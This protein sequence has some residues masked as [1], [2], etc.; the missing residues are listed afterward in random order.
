MEHC[1]DT[2]ATMEDVHG[3]LGA[4]GS[5]DA[6]EIECALWNA[7]I[8]GC[9]DAL[10]AFH[11]TDDDEDEGGGE[12]QVDA[13][14]SDNLSF[15]GVGS[16]GAS[17]DLDANLAEC[18]GHGYEEQHVEE[19]GDEA[20]DLLAHDIDPY[21]DAMHDDADGGFHANVLSKPQSFNTNI[22]HSEVCIYFTC[23]LSLKL[24]LHLLINTFCLPRLS[25]LVVFLI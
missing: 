9:K 18:S 4:T 22:P 21:E 1:P 23:L 20:V 3:A 13:R 12:D 14:M 16:A 2:D 11:S 6:I 7:T 5:K 10:L 8:S 17:R 19:E 25:I 15:G 24:D